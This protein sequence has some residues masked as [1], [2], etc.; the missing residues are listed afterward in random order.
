MPVDPRPPEWF[1]LRDYADCFAAF[2]RALGLDQV[3]L[4]GLSFGGALVLAT[5]ERHRTLTRS[6]VLMGAYA[7]WAGSLGPEEAEKRLQFCLGVADLQPADF[8]R[9]MLASMFSTSA[10]E[11]AVARFAAGVRAFDPAGFRAMAHASAEADLR[12]I[13]PTVDVPTLILNGDQDVRAPLT[14]AAA[15]RDAIPRSRLVVLPGVGHVSSVEAPDL[16]NR[17][18]RSF[19]AGI[20]SVGLGERDAGRRLAR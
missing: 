18:I 16:V 13:L 3:H 20:G 17:E 9:A 11:E 15:L 6:L 7:G 5:F 8:E 19:L 1:R 10:P 14:V 12:N 4:V 2:L